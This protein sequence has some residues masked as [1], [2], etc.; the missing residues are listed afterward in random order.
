MDLS[1]PPHLPTGTTQPRAVTPRQ[2]WASL[3]SGQMLVR[4]QG[5]LA[6]SCLGACLPAPPS[7]IPLP[8]NPA[9]R[10]RPCGSHSS[11]LQLT[12]WARLRGLSLQVPC[13]CQF[14]CG[15]EERG[16]GYWERA[17]LGH[18]SQGGPRPTILRHNRIGAWEEALPG[19][20]AGMT[21]CGTCCWDW[22]CC[23]SG[24]RG[25]T[26]AAGRE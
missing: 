2:C 16:R 6:Q 25:L 9:N 19:V 14:W 13:S 12:K 10:I 17:S 22:N 5:R 15:C 20:G 1:V 26:S 7:S 8:L 21:S 24:V 3:G 23:S 4:M 11:F 18:P